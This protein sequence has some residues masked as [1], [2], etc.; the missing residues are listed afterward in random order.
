MARKPARHASREIGETIR[1][2]LAEGHPSQQGKKAKGRGERMGEGREEGERKRDGTGGEEE[3]RGGEGRDLGRGETGREGREVTRRQREG[4]GTWARENGN[5]EEE[6]EDGTGEGKR[7]EHRD[8]LFLASITPPLPTPLSRPV[9][10]P[11]RSLPFP[12]PPRPNSLPSHPSTVLL[13]S[14]PPGEGNSDSSPPSLQG[15][16]KG[17]IKIKYF[18]LIRSPN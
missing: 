7:T 2:P 1:G 8:V 16:R 14:L 18:I 9:P 15:R 5:G 10:F 4:K 3:A 13:P 11:P 12:F 6:G 17:E